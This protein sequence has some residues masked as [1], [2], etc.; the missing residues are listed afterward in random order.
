MHGFGPYRFNIVESHP[1]VEDGRFMDPLTHF[2]ITYRF[3]GHNPAALVAGLAADIPFYLTYPTWIIRRGQLITAVQT[4][5]WP[6][7]PGWM[8]I[9][10]H[11]GHSLPLVI[12]LAVLFRLRT[13]RWP[14]W[15]VAWALHILIDIP[16]HARRD[17]APQ[18]L[19]PVSSLTV[20]G[21]SW[22]RLLI[23]FVQR[24]SCKS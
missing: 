16:T 7:A 11:I 10:H 2:L 1:D 17:W 20:D 9:P 14:R 3:V 21:I 23:T 15:A 24:F 6:E 18:F 19:W 4:N 13:G 5:D 8:T 12:G 22:P